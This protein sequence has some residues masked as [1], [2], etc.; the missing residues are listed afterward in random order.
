MPRDGSQTDP[1]AG[2]PGRE[3]LLATKLYLPA[4]RPNLVPRPRLIERLNDG[5]H[6]GCKL[7]L[8]SAPAGFGKTTLLVEWLE[9]RE[10]AK[11]SSSVGWLSLDEDDNDPA[12]F[13]AYL[14][15]ALRRTEATVDLDN[16]AGPAL[17]QSVRLREAMAPLIN[18][19]A[20]LSQTI[21]LVLDDYHLIEHE[22]IHD[23][24]SFLLD[25]LP[26]NL[27]LII[28]GR[29]DPPLPLPR[30]RV[31][32]QIT[33]L[34]QSDLRFR[35]EEAAAFLSKTMGLALSDE[36]VIQL[37]RRTE[38]WIAGLQLAAL[39][40]QGRSDVEAFIQAFSGSHHY[41]LDYLAQEVL[42]RQ[43][44]AVR[45]FLCQTSILERLCAPLCD[46]VLGIG[47]SVDWDPSFASQSTLERLETA[48]LFVVPLD[49]ERRWYRYHRLFAEFLQRQLGQSEPDLVSILHRRASTWYAQ[50]G[51]RVEAIEHALAGG[52]FER[53]A[54]LIEAEAEA[55]LMRSEIT[56]YLAWV[57]ALP[58]KVVRS[59]PV[60]CLY[61]AWALLL[62]ARP[63]HE[64][65]ARLQ[66]ADRDRTEV[67]GE[68]A[69]LRAFLSAFQGEEARVADLPRRLFEPTLE[70]EP[71]LRS[72]AAWYLGFS[73]MWRGD[74]GAAEHTLEQ[75]VRI[76]QEAGNVM[77][78]AMALCHRAEV[79]ML[80]GKLRAARSLYQ[81]ALDLAV[82]E[83]G[84]PLPIAG[85]ALIGLGELARER[86][87][88]DQARRLLDEGLE[89]TKQWGELGTLDGYIA[90]ARLAQAQN[91]LQGL[92]E[93][94]ANAVQFA[95]RFDATD[96]DDRFVEAHQAR[97]WAMQGQFSKVAQ[98]VESHGLALECTA[99]D[100]GDTKSDSFRYPF[101]YLRDIECSVLA[102]LLIGHNR[103]QDGLAILERLLS[104]IE[105][106]GRW[107]SVIE[108]H[109]LRALALQARGH[110]T[111]AGSALEQALSLAGPEGYVRIFA[112]EG[113]PMA[114]LL[115][116]AAARGVAP[117]Y[118][119]QLLAAIR[120]EESAPPS[121]V[122]QLVEPLSERELQVLRLIVT[123]LSNQQIAEELVLAVSTIKW[124]IN[125]LYSKLGVGSR[126]QAIA[127]AR[128]LDLI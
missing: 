38:G 127:R 99:V 87:E 33:E 19:M 45:R 76:S 80:Q 82:D 125:N 43:P 72:L 124:H 35:S 110:T 24:M 5:L 52:D 41:V 21:L 64:I 40:M 96:L 90:L 112:D 12:R 114:D 120:T 60:L 9:G 3:S 7:I 100:S 69:V 102:R 89:R 53:A 61:Q 10:R 97:I 107:G 74:F 18:E 118:V 50:Q 14:T 115:R 116:Q 46:A 34:R 54:D 105:Q 119:G 95:R 30:L 29:T 84:A 88:L 2:A 28:A 98:W 51:F 85:M 55:V 106:D 68:M 63:S 39:S 11:A 42:R 117:E 108:I 77:L 109:V 15:A 101:R 37:E 57:D 1:P 78:A 23:A 94:M 92:E 59:R 126:T 86:D 104:P 25:H 79:Y 20:A 73:C 8:I 81:Q 75:A 113:E 48:N 26:P 128:E 123:G 49:P 103:P 71:L 65:L 36:G 93:A 66:D 58:D 13:L 27:H 121:D 44:V 31:Q 6:L 83:K 122:P 16:L 91:D 70:G 56:T 111:Q 17:P 22:A 67:S 62:A 47:V 32:G 4:V